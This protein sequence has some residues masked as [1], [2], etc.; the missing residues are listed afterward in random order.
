MKQPLIL[1]SN[2]DGYQAKGIHALVEMIHDLGD[3]IV[4]APEGAR[5]GK[6]RAFTMAE[7]SLRE[8]T[9][10]D[11]L[12]GTSAENLRIYACSGTPVDC[13]KIAC[14]TVCNRKPDLIIGGI[15]HGDN[16]STNAHYSGTCGIAFEG[17]IKGIPSI[18]FSLC[19]Y[20]LDADFEPM[21][22][23][24]RTK[25][26]EVLRDGLPHST[27]LNINVPKVADASELKGVRI[28]RMADGVW[29]NEVEKI[30]GKTD[31]NGKP[32]YQLK[33]YFHNNEPEA[34]DTDAWAIANG[35]IAVTPSTIDVTAHVFFNS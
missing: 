23:I 3:I 31:E 33:G 17:A 7:L 15:N 27:F 16:A 14:G 1:I 29:L 9:D 21:R 4:C 11:Y 10:H 24:V 13:I 34:E 35:Y 2:D 28:C 12:P 20:D 8:I 25:C 18:A 19:D 32:L 6:S 30:E 5:S 26:Q 22:D